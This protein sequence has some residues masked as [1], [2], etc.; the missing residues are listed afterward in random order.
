MT[1]LVNDFI[2]SID[3]TRKDIRAAKRLASSDIYVIAANKE[4]AYALRGYKEWIMKLS[5]NAKAV[6]RT[7][8]ILLYRVRID[9]L[10]KMNEIATVAKA[11]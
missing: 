11:I 4:E 9:T 3:I 1:K 2:K 7:Y 6:T 10:L 5:K 8:G